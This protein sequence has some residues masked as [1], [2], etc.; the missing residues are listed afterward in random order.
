M[1]K[2]ER[3]YLVFFAGLFILLVAIEYNSPRPVNWNATFSKKDKIPYGGYVLFDCLS[4]IFP[5][6]NIITADRGLYNTL[7][8][9]N[10]YKA[11]NYIIISDN[12]EPDTLDMNYL[13][14]YVKKGNTAFIAAEDFDH[15]FAD[16]LGFKCDNEYG[17]NLLGKDS[18]SINFSNPSLHS[19]NNFRYKNGTVE[20]YFKSF[21]STKTT[22]L[23]TNSKTKANLIS[24]K[25]GKGTFYLSSIPYAFTNYNALKGNNSEYIFR[26]L[27]YLPIA[28]TYW[29]EYYK[30]GGDK[31]ATTP[32]QFLLTNPALKF[33]YYTLIF[34]VL[35]YVIFEGKRKQRII[36]VI[37]P[38]KN[39]SIE[40][41]E[42][43]GRLHFQKRA[44]NTVAQKKIA[45]FLDY[46]RSHY[47]VSTSDFND[48][49]YNSLAAKTLLPV[50]DIRN[51]FRYIARV[52]AAPATDEAMLMTLNEQI[53]NFYNK[54]Q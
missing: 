7:S 18:T 1:K 52:Q 48:M 3:K 53:E 19:Q 37:T 41:T 22:V 32:L 42:T 25:Y 54:T 28:D 50:E 12:F 5:N 51:L 33:A 40:F 6:K 24:V 34:A 16:S 21:D 39:T 20:T 9:D 8:A 31:T 11:N 15:A 17:F 44:Y 47:N 10:G 38:L 4:D 26:A 46:I 36:P 35:L 45:F 14:N 29:D 2:N 30:P 23:G 49:L 27:S 43:I 13:A